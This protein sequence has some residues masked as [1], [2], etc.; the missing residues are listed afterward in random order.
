MRAM[1]GEWDLGAWAFV[2][3]EFVYA[4]EQAGHEDCVGCES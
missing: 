1:N 3:L 4:P 2:V